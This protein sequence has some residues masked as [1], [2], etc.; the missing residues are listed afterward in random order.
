[1]GHPE[2][3]LLGGLFVAIWLATRLALR[4][5]RAPG[6]MLSRSAGAALLAAGLT[7]FLLVPLAAAIRDS[8]RAVNARSF[9]QALPVSLAPHGPA[10]PSGF[11]TALLPRALGDAMA[12]PML[13]LAPASFPEMALGHFGLVGCAAAALLFRR[14]SRRQR[15]AVA[16]VVPLVTGFATAIAMWPIFEFFYVLPG[17]RLMLPLRF[18]S[19]V[20]LG[21]SALAAFEADRLAKDVE[22]GRASAAPILVSSAALLVVVVA[23][24]EKLRPLHAVAGAVAVQK[25][26]AIGAAIFLAAAALAVIALSR[27]S[28]LRAFPVFPVILAVLATGELFWQGRRLYRSG[29]ASDFY[30][31]TPLVEFLGRQPRPF[32]VVGEGAAVFPSTNVFAGVEDVRV[33]DP[34]ERRDY[35]EWLDRACGYDPKAYFKHI[36]NSDCAAFDFLNVKY[37]VGGPGRGAPGARWRPVYSGA[38][39]TVFENSAVL[40]RIFPAE[41]GAARISGYRETTNEVTFSADVSVP[42]A[43]LASSLA[44]DGGWTARDERNSPLPVARADGPFLA[45]TVPGGR[46]RVRLR[47]APPGL[48][49]GIAVSLASAAIALAAAVRARRTTGV[50]PHL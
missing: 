13:P 41:S 22:E 43:V 36:A 38:D 3:V 31:L 29:P 6:S 40:P 35:V 12:T 7:A 48:R 49:T 27:G 2:S 15:S 4:D 33:H 18:L 44:T 39:G 20:S 21:G 47:Y 37:F 17:V 16:L 50:A 23:F 30:P 8:N 32:R 46:H 19:W 42:R 26:E 24:L 14:G 25:R 34:V 5:L 9:S 1:A 10:W 11:V 45:V 28:W